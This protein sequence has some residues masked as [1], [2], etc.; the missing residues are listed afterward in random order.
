MPKKKSKGEEEL[1]K[2]REKEKKEKMYAHNALGNR[3]FKS[4][5]DMNS[6]A[7]AARRHYRN[8]HKNEASIFE[9]IEFI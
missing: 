6:A 4:L 7:D 8:T 5:D 2:V 3:N 1:S 9:Q